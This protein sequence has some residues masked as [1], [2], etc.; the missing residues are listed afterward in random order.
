MLA[1]FPYIAH[2]LIES[3]AL[4][5]VLTRRGRPKLIGGALLWGKYIV[6]ICDVDQQTIEESQVNGQLRLDH[7]RVDNERCDLGIPVRELHDIEHIRQFALA[8]SP[9]ASADSEIL[10]HL[11]I[12]ENDTWP[13][14]PEIAWRRV[15]HDTHISARNR[16]SLFK[17]RQEHL[18]QHRM[19]QVIR[20]ELDLT[21]VLGRSRWHRHDACIAHEDIESVGFGSEFHS[22]P[23]TESSDARSHPTKLTDTELVLARDA[24]ISASHGFQAESGSAWAD[25]RL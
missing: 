16:C 9:P 18:D 24:I 6:D 1:P 14:S 8:I 13:G 2:R 19:A 20:A 10:L 17:N 3:A 12:L 5:I 23:C 22:P 7:P 4:D 25:V 15:A 11:Q 21:S